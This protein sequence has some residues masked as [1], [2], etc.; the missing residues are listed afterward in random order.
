V[1]EEM[2]CIRCVMKATTE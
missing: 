2:L 1:E